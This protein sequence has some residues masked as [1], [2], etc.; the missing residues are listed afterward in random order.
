LNALNRRE[1][2]PRNFPQNAVFQIPEAEEGDRMKHFITSLIASALLAGIALAQN[3]EINRREQNQRERIG[4]GVQSGSLS[5]RE[6]AR[7][8]AREAS[9]E[10]QEQRDRADGRGY[11]A[12]ERARTN[13]R[14]NNT[15]KA[16]YR[17]KHD[18]QTR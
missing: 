6:A 18:G 15:S 2:L 8:R 12:R 10:A 3:G 13:R 16:I 9:I 5:K 4:N 1:D 11:T 14:L 17:Q 7:L